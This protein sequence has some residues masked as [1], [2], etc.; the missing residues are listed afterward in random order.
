MKP[1]L[2][3][4]ILGTLTAL[5]AIPVAFTIFGQGCQF[6]SDSANSPSVAGSPLGNSQC[7]TGKII[8]DKNYEVKPGERTVAILYGNQLLDSFVA[9]TGIGRPSARTA[10]EFERRQQSFS[11]YGLLI[12]FSGAMLMGV[13]A[14]AAEVCRDALDRE[15][16]MAINDSGRV[17]FRGVDLARTGLNRAEAE[18]IS[19]A[20]AYSCWQ[21]IPTS[22]ELDLVSAS[23]QELSRLQLN[24][25]QGALGICTALLSSLSA[26]EL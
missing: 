4:R 9:C 6:Q 1:Y 12:D 22:E 8:V 14:V 10:D 17:L 23:A 16:N 18:S 5:V 3:R 25:E 26:I 2:R 11:E 21:K 7:G 15:M 13:T 24:S 19:R 20:V